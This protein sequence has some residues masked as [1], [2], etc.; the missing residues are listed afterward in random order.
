M[1][2]RKPTYSRKPKLP[3]PVEDVISGAKELGRQGKAAVERV[4]EGA[5]KIR[6]SVGR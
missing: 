4:K 2:Y 3:K 5:R 6:R 1:P